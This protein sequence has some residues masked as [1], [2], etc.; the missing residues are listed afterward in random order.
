GPIW[1]SI[2]DS[3][4]TNLTFDEV[5]QL[6]QAAQ[7]IPK[8]N[9]QSAVITD[10][11]GY[12]LPQT[13]PSGEQ[14]FSPIYEKIHGLVDTLFDSAPVVAPSS[15]Q[16]NSD[17]AAEAAKVLVSNGAGVDGMAK[18]TADKL[19]AKG[20]NITDAKNADLPG[21]YGKTIIRV[22]TDKF[23]TAKALA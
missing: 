1:A 2:K 4:K 16:T 12:L 22:Y 11:D 7:N 8:E 9:I 21:G 3:I 20:F 23:K 13:L 6:A 10:K 5:I 19:R 14:V 18:S 17:V 15:N